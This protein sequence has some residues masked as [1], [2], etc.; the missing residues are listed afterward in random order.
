MKTTEA[1]SCSRFQ[2]SK[3]N[4]TKD[5]PNECNAFV[6]YSFFVPPESLNIT[7]EDLTTTA[8]SQVFPLSLFEDECRIPATKLGFF[9]FFFFF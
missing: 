1:Q 9:I 4:P 5:G 6:D 2:G 8:F 7:R 3:D